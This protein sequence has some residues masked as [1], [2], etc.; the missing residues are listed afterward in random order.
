M[1]DQFYNTMKK[2]KE[3]DQKEKFKTEKRPKLDPKSP[4]LALKLTI[5]LFSLRGGRFS[6]LFSPISPTTHLL[7]KKRLESFE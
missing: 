2:A 5:C 4:L 7:S 3:S 6:A 1:I